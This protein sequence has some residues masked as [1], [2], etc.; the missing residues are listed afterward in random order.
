MSCQKFTEINQ[1]FLQFLKIPIVYLFLTTLTIGIPVQLLHS[2]SGWAQTSIDPKTTAIELQKQGVS[3]LQTSQYPA[4]ITSFQ[5]A[6][7]IYQ[8]IGDRSG[9]ADSLL[10]LG[11]VYDTIGKVPEAIQYYQQSLTI[12]RELGN[13]SGEADALNN[14]GMSSRSLGQ[15]QQALNFL[16]PSL[17]LAKELGDQAAISRALGNLGNVYYSMAQYQKALDY[18]Q[19]SLAIS[20][21]LQDQ[22]SIV[23]SLGNVGN[24]YYYIGQYEK[25]IDF[26]KQQQALAQKIGA[27]LYE[28]NALGNLGNVYS[29][30]KNYH[31]AVK[32]YQQSLEIDQK[33]GNQIGI[34]SCLGNIGLTYLYL[35]D[36]QQARDFLAKSLVANQQLGDRVGEANTLNNLGNLELALKQNQSALDYQEKSLA[37]RQQIGDRL[38]EI[39][40]LNNI[41]TILLDLGKLPEAE[42]KLRTA[43]AIQES[44]R[45]E[46]VQD[47][48]K[49]SLF[50]TQASAY[51]NLQQVLIQEKKINE[52]L[53]IAERGRARA[54]VELLAKRLATDSS[55]SM[56]ITPPNINQI[57]Q[58]AKQHHATL[59]EYSI[60]LNEYLYIWVVKPTGEIGFREVNL[61]SLNQQT[62]T[63]QKL[64][65]FTRTSSNLNPKK[66]LDIRDI[67]LKSRNALFQYQ[68]SLASS[69]LKL[70]HQIL[71]A[72]IA[73]L[74]PTDPTER[75]I[76]IPQKE[77]FLI[78]FPALKDQQDKYL[79]E[80]HTILTAPAIQVLDLT[81]QQ[82]QKNQQSGA[83]SA[84]IVGLPRDI[85]VVGN[86]K[87]PSVGDPP[88]PL[89]QL[90]G[91]EIEAKTIAKLLNT[92]AIIGSDATKAKILAA[93]TKARIIHLATHGLLDD[94]EGLGV[95]GAIALAPSG[96]DNGLLT[97][98][99]ILKLKLNADLVV[100][101]ACNTGKGRITGDGVIGLSRS[102]I[103]AGVPSAI[104][105]LWSIPDAPTADLMNE[106]YQNLRQNP[107]KARALRNAMLSTMQKHPFPTDWAAF[108]LIGEPD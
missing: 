77:L 46:L 62:G 63:E 103:T 9:I 43:I 44:I 105:T 106:F 98:N 94:I 104:V 82:K 80:Q 2:E 54:F 49:I 68:G 28:A 74:L 41:A 86:P 95:P 66:I 53:E 35:N 90:I 22:P 16:L 91:A 13:R 34:S 100:L 14:L 30:T 93:M 38:G 55:T 7:K 32:Y 64:T 57:K 48:N 40:S 42:A 11:I 31:E 3:Q 33:I 20:Q 87:M 21:Q 60:I 61:Q 39:T 50:D 36:Y 37:I 51:D 83:Q 29:D 89:P 47:T 108:T 79:I 88:Q 19:Q 99:E 15:Y 8:Q 25:A 56:E 17:D 6:L 18:H 101:S 27:L 107:D 76:F 12:F 73:D 65:E 59:V 52:S 26:Y 70:L 67:F 58:I 1:L 4:A 24:A 81:W 72:P 102:L 92:E 45:S 84:L 5:A 75:V 71:I 96:Q 69:K 23:E 85:V 10:D 97:A 78:P